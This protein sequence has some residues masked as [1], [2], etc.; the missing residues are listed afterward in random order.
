MKDRE[1]KMSRLFFKILIYS[2]FWTF[3]VILTPSFFFLSSCSKANTKQSKVTTSEEISVL[4]KRAYLGNLDIFIDSDAKVEYRKIV[5]L[6]F[7]VSGKV[8]KVFVS[9]AQKVQK[10]QLLASLDKEVYNFQLQQAYQNYLA[11]KANYEQAIY[12]YKIQKI[13]IDSDYKKALL[14]LKQAKENL[15][16]TET[17]LYQ[18]KKDFERYNKLYNE[19]VIS[20]QQ[21]ENIKIQYQNALNNYYNAKTVLQQM[22][23]NLEVLKLK[24][25]RLAIFENQAKAAYW[26]SFS[27]YKNYSIIKENYKYTDLYSP[28]E[29]IILKKNIDEGTVVNPSFIAL[30][31]GD[32]NS[33][34]V[35]ASISDIDAKKI[36]I[37]TLA[38]AYFKNKE[39][40]IKVNKIYPNLNSVGFSYIEANFLGDNELNHNDY[41][42]IKIVTKSVRGILIPRQALVYSDKEIYVYV[43]EN[44]K[45]VKKTVKILETSGD[46]CVVEGVEEGEKV[47]ID[48][49]YF[50][51]EGYT[52][53]EVEKE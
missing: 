40:P 19:G 28:F 6:S 12:N 44:G 2:V 43:V 27:A 9:E 17:I 45:A 1:E 8:S 36:K 49:Q 11:S 39:Y 21:F 3:L 47:V 14:S 38:I 34:I 35:K 20:A 41:V 4:V 51:K 22:E 42:N 53:K 10:G 26:N 13:Q 25:E 33:K 32:P 5:N 7:Q 30:S 31:I 16:L 48:G 18:S 46:L 23:D 15:Y 29:G 24:K 52:V 37:P 50:L